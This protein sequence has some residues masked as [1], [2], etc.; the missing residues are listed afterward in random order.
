[1][2]SVL[3]INMRRVVAAAGGVAT[4]ALAGCGSS[5]DYKNEARPPSPIVVTAYISDEGVSVSPDKFGAGPVNLVITNQSGAAQQVTF[6][7]GGAAAGF[8]QQTG[9]INPRDTATLKADIPQ[10][11]AVVK[12]DSRAIK[13]AR[14]RVGAERPSAQNDLLQP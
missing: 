5:G 6:Q 8:T 1:M 4:L 3:H 2:E 9:P 11:D 12:V 7:S 14:I 13:A 10:G